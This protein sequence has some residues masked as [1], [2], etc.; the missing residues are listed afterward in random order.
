MPD[1]NRFDQM[2]QEIIQLLQA[3]LE[4]LADVSCLTDHELEACYNRQ[5][6]VRQ[7]RDQLSVATD[8][9]SHDATLSGQRSSSPSADSEAAVA[10]L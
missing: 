7:L 10:I 2:R 9:K 5:E 6:R 1:N 4:A 8:R 3:Q